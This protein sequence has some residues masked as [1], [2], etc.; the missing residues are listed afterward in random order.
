LRT[1][2]IPRAEDLVIHKMVAARPR[3]VDDVERVLARHGSTADLERIEAVVEEFA[4]A[5][6]DRTRPEI[7]SGLL[8]R[9]GLRR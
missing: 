5:L 3:D 7:L 9:L 1:V 2:R 8:K 6:D 4:R